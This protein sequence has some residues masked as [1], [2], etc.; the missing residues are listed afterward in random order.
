MGSCPQSR[1]ELWG[2]DCAILN[3]IIRACAFRF[4]YVICAMTIAHLVIVCTNKLIFSKERFFF[5]NLRQ[6]QQIP[7]FTK[8]SFCDVVTSWLQTILNLIPQTS[9]INTLNRRSSHKCIV[10]IASRLV[11]W[12]QPLKFSQRTR[13]IIIDYSYYL[14]KRWLALTTLRRAIRARS[15]APDFTCVV[16]TDVLLLV[17]KI[18]H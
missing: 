17:Y 14:V 12:S 5:S 13:F 9:H 8:F 6:F 11:W 2:R 18:V 7:N 16:Y 1:E 4:W 3:Y 15:P 10:F